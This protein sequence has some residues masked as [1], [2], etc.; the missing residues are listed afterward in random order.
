[1]INYIIIS[2]SGK[3][4]Y[5]FDNNNIIVYSAII[6]SIV[7]YFTY[8][9]SPNQL[10]NSIKNNNSFINFA[11]Y[12]PFILISISPI[13]HHSN[14]SSLSIL[15]N[16]LIS[17][18]SKP[19][20]DKIF[21]K[22]P[23]FDFTKLLSNSDILTLN[24]ICHDLSLNNNAI[25]N[26]NSLQTLPINY[27]IRSKINSK[28]NSLSTS[29]LLFGLITTSN[30]KLI[31]ILK[32]IQNSN[33][34]LHI[35][36]LSILFKIISSSNNFKLNSQ[37]ITNETFWLPI[38]LPK[39]NS[40][41]HLYTLI[42]FVE[43]NDSRYQQLHS[44]SPNGDN[45]DKLL[46][47]LMSPFKDSF[48]ELKKISNNLIKSL[49]FNKKIFNSIYN[50]LSINLPIPSSII[51]YTIKNTSLLQFIESH[52]NSS[53]F[54]L[55]FKNSTIIIENYSNYKLFACKLSNYEIYLKINSSTPESQL[56]PISKSILNYCIL[57]NHHL[58]IQ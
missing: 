10:I 51:S 37:Y 52:S 34:N 33:H 17:L 11:H 8:S 15:Y 58:F 35:S 56:L 13:N 12:N 53:L 32:N 55:N 7:S 2:S 18:L 16:Y 30:F 45:T 26:Y 43:L 1:M 50:P 36:D 21:D 47:I 40:N 19:Y 54:P 46:I 57:N 38:C 25:F 14:P 6:Q 23:N 22:Y 4:I 29:N 41:G 48:N 5:A 27:K 39:F 49:L 28:F 9:T 3:P 20:I 24:S 42:Q 31:S 44:I